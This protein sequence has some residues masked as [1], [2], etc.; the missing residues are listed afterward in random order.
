MSGQTYYSLT[1]KIDESAELQQVFFAPTEDL[2]AV[3]NHTDDLEGKKVLTIAGSGDSVIEFLL[4]GAIVTAVDIR[5]DP[6]KWT[7][8]KIAAINSLS[9]QEYANFM[10]A[11]NPNQ[12]KEY[13]YDFERAQNA[14]Y[15][16][17]DEMQLVRE[18]HTAA[19]QFAD[20]FK[21]DT[22]LCT[23]RERFFYKTRNYLERL[24]RCS[25]RKPAWRINFNRLTLKPTSIFDHSILDPSQGFS[26]IHLSNAMEYECFD[27]H[28]FLYHTDG[29]AD[30]SQ[31]PA[32]DDTKL[33]EH[34]NRLLRAVFDVLTRDGQASSITFGYFKPYV[35]MFIQAGKSAGFEVEHHILE[36]EVFPEQGDNLFVYKR[37]I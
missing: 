26:H 14:F 1:A 24:S 29:T 3:M 12:K 20:F 31:L 9:E 28:K 16:I 5:E 23:H 21:S 18:L 6:L 17:K 25:F 8:L 30:H 22:A 4:K 15:R 2:T 10:N 33:F 37:P 35:E 27:P 7:R 13:P 32:Y 36:S 34:R 19:E 11:L